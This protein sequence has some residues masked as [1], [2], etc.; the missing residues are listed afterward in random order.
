[1]FVAVVL[2]HYSYQTKESITLV[3]AVSRFQIPVINGLKRFHRAIISNNAM[4]NISGDT[5]KDAD[6]VQRV[7]FVTGKHYYELNKQR[8][9]LGLKDV[10]I[11]RLE[12]LSPFPTQHLQQEIAK[13]KNAK[14][15]NTKNMFLYNFAVI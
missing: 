13:Y 10:A 6:Q 5:V 14:C 2:V 12:G 15:K 3:T 9:V 11:V 4:S 8:Q 7:I 1:M